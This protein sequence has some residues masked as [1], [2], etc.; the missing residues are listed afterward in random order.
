MSKGPEQVVVPDV[1]GQDVDAATKELEDAG[2]EVTTTEVSSSKPENE[3]TKQ[4]PASG[5][6]ADDGS[7]VKLT[8]ASGQNTSRTWSD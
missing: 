1:V 5:G 2:F 8:V 7:K 3:V 6:K 4:S